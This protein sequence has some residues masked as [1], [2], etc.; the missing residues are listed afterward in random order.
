MKTN[1][2]HS[3]M[4]RTLVVIGIALAL[5]TTCTHA[6]S[7][8]P[9]GTTVYS[10]LNDKVIPDHNMVHEPPFTEKLLYNFTNGM[11]GGVPY[12][13]LITDTSNPPNFYGTAST[14]GTGNNCSL[15]GGC[16]V[17]FE[18]LAP[19][20]TTEVTLYSFCQLPN[21]A[22]GASPQA[23]LVFGKGRLF[24]TTYGGGTSGRGTVFE[25]TLANGEWTESAVYSFAGTPDGAFPQYG[26][27]S[28][29]RGA[30]YGTTT[31]GGN[32]TTN[33]DVGCGTVF[34]VTPTKTGLSE[35]VLHSFQGASNNDGMQPSG[36][37]V[38]DTSGNLYGATYEGGQNGYN[39]GTLFELTSASNY[40]DEM[41]LHTFQGYPSD[42]AGP[43]GGVAISAN[44]LFL[45]T[46]SGGTVD[47]INTNGQQ[48]CGQ[49]GKFPLPSGPY[50]QLWNFGGPPTD[51]AYPESAPFLESGHLYGAT[52]Y[53]GGGSCMGNLPG[54]GAVYKVPMAGALEKVLYSFG[55]MP[56]GA[57]PLGSVVTVGKNLYGTTSTGGNID[58]GTVFRVY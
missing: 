21:C 37:V 50:M 11:D 16:G 48:G 58:Q 17:V 43:R 55:G 25:L 27:L 57:Y 19:N 53:G 30:L 56:D 14:G 4:K 45:A 18:L 2:L 36:T 1:M 13:N 40:N 22:D 33:C 51:G 46:E 32:S 15:S 20:Y 52:Y 44:V 34:S 41:V 42:G 28:I 47:C 35:K 8:V 31:A 3:E 54:C 38:F 5:W 7:G 6:Q 24:G 10:G 49:L 39:I 12:S 23:G 29:Y 26:S 9:A